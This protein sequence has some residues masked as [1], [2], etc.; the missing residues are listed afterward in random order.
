MVSFLAAEEQQRVLSKRVYDDRKLALASLLLQKH[1][2]SL[3]TGRKWDSIR[4]RR[5]TTGKPY[6]EGLHYN[7]SHADGIVV[8]VGS[9]HAIGVDVVARDYSSLKYLVSDMDQLFS[10]NEM[11]AMSGVDNSPD[12]F[13]LCWAFK[14]AYMKYNGFPNWDNLASM[15]FLDIKIPSTSNP[16]CTNAVSKILDA[17]V[18]QSGYTET[19]I[20][21]ES[22][23]IAIYTSHA[24]TSDKTTTQFEPVSLEEIVKSLR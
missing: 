21:G 15:E 12:L 8:L 16:N 22:H 5:T 1:Y 7:V 17:G 11:A 18:R 3:S 2:I 4:I 6:F 10:S 24:P 9:N 13:L 20:I 19:H 23:L 14:E